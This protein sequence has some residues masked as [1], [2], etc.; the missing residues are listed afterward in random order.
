MAESVYGVEVWGPYAVAAGQDRALPWSCTPVKVADQD[1][2]CFQVQRFP[3][4]VWYSQPTA[5]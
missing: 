1:L 3:L 5:A 4:H 2:A